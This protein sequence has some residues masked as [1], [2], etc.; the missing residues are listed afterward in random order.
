MEMLKLLRT[1]ME[2]LK[3][4]R[5]S[6]EMLKLLR[7]SMRM[8]DMGKNLKRRKS[9]WRIRWMGGGAAAAQP[10]ANVSK[11]S[12]EPSAISINDIVRKKPL[13]KGIEVA[14][15]DPATPMRFNLTFNKN[16]RCR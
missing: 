3:L 9:L 10:G 11:R 13:K 5:T 14:R 15:S 4:L 6:M 8:L 1:S 16:V 2:M 7:T 12:G